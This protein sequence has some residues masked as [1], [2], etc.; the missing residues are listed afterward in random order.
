MVGRIF[1]VQKLPLRHRTFLAFMGV[2]L[3]L[4]LA[5]TIGSA[6]F[7]SGI[8]QQTA[9]DRLLALQEVIYRELKTQ[10]DLLLTYSAFLN[11]SEAA[12]H[13]GAAEGHAEIVR[14]RIYR[15]LG[16][17][18]MTVAFFP[19]SLIWELPYSSLRDL[20][21]HAF[22]SGQARTRFADDLSNFPTLAVAAPVDPAEPAPM[23]MLLQ[24][25]LDRTVLNRMGSGFG[26]RIALLTLEGRVLVSC[27]ENMVIP[28][29]NS[30]DL[31]TVLSG[32]SVFGRSDTPFPRT[33]L[34][35]AVPLGT[36]DVIISMTEIPTGDSGGTVVNLMI[37]S[38]LTLLCALLLATYLYRRLTRRILRS[39]D[40][41]LRAMDAVSDGN[42]DIRLLPHS[43]D[44]L[45]RLAAS[46][47]SM[48][49]R[50]Q[51]LNDR[52]ISRT[53]ELVRAQEANR[54]TR[55]LEKKDTEIE[56]TNLEL[57]NSLE[58]LSALFQLNQAMNSTLEMDRL[59]DRMLDVLRDMVHYD[60][61]A[62]LLHRP[63]MED[64]EVRRATGI[65]AEFLEK[66][67]CRLNG[68]LIGRVAR[69]QELLYLPNLETDYPQW[70][71]QGG[72]LSGASL[73]CAPMVVKKR[74]AGVLLLLKKEANGYGEAE[75]RLTRAVSN[76]AAIAIEN[77]RLYERMRHL[78]SIDEL[79]GLSNRHHF[80]EILGRE[81]AQAQR[82]GSGFSLIL[83]DID[84]FK[85]FN[86]SCGHLSGDLALKQV[87]RILL[88]N[89]RQIDLAAR[90][91]GEEFVIL[92]PRTDRAG[93]LAA[94]EKL[95]RCMEQ[96]TFAGG[97]QDVAGRTLTLSIGLAEFPADGK[98]MY[99]LLDSADR[100]LYRAKKEGRNRTASQ[101]VDCFRR[102]FTLGETP[103]S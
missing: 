44:E 91:G 80:Q 85:E 59:L 102:T 46:F 39:T 89:T 27:D 92:L 10:E 63:G 77:A 34:F 95:H 48:A 64:L 15:S 22:R 50:L 49:S 88:Q 5:V 61:M 23:I 2:L 97:G 79:T 76:Q 19:P 18:G 87:A 31:E 1:N 37:R 62:L 103:N 54:Y 65:E 3:L 86:E 21:D 71:Y 14:D 100:A 30:V 74:L 29:L 24:S 43:A 33:F 11:Y 60:A 101:A 57:K 20:L 51:D 4:G 81:I 9:E 69:S 82:Y 17:K 96:A 26:G 98:E 45:G 58:E 66:S 73:I 83:A 68:T 56:K 36:T 47:N 6:H 99:E 93:A 25:P 67:H 16:D 40:D 13:L 70:D 35:R 32:G 42:H 8:F 7:I 41:L 12:S 53:T 75:I 55:L 52:N 94:A 72:S 38:L 28:S 78:S 90:F 84:H